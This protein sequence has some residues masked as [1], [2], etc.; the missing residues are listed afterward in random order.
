LLGRSC[1]LMPGTIKEC[2]KLQRF[3]EANPKHAAIDT[4]AA[5]SILKQSAETANL[6]LAGRLLDEAILIEPKLA[7]AHFQKG[8]LLQCQDQWRES[9]PELETSTALK[10]ESSRAHYRLALAYA[11]TG[12]QEKVKEQVALQK[13]YRAQEKDGLDARLSEITIFLV[14]VH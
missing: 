5:A 13:K 12:N 6:S 9:I 8:F 1:T 2:D 3:A 7:E 10:P 11:R 14:N 4:Y